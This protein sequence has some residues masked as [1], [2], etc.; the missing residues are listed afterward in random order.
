[1]HGS[2]RSLGDGV[3][4]FVRQRTHGSVDAP[5]AVAERRGGV[6][7]KVRA[8]PDGEG[9]AVARATADADVRLSLVAAA[10]NRDAMQM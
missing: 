10:P 4:L 3:R 7:A 6:A 2:G 5:W 9:S 1:M 8:G